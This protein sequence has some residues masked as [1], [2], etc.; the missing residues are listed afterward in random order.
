MA[1]RKAQWH[2][3]R[4]FFGVAAKN[5]RR[6]LIDYAHKRRAKKRGGEL[7]KLPLD[8][9]MALAVGRAPDLIALDDALKDLAKLDARQSQIV[10]LRIFGG[11]TRD[12]IADLFGISLRAVKSEWKTVLAW[13]RR[14]LSRA[15]QN[16]T[17]RTEARKSS[18]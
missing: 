9:A 11:F 6:V 18:D 15:K 16:E 8:E 10:E 5:M 17:Q 7:I 3:R 12:Q 2:S 14:E 13:L 1:G 4:E